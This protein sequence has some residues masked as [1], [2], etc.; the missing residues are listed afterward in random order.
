M[1]SRRAFALSSLAIGLGGEAWAQ[2]RPAGARRTIRYAQTPGAPATLQS[3]DLYPA[4]NRNAPL[5]VFIHGGGWRIGDKQNGAAGEEKASFFNALG[6]A[7]AS[8]NYRLSPEVQ[9]PAH[10]E[11]VAAALAWLHDNAAAQGFDRD[12]ITIMGHSAGAHLAALVAIDPR[13]LGKH[14]KPLSIVKGVILLDGAGY[15]VTRQAPAVIARGGF[16]GEMYS[17][18]FGADPA[19]WRDASPTLLV[20]RGRAIAPFLIVHA[21]RP[22]STSQSRTLAA[23]LRDVGVDAQL[24][25]AHGYTHAQVNRR[26]GETGEAVTREITGALAR[27]QG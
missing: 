1:M 13:Y 19:G 22:D 8:L 6:N 27:W 10:V 12:R 4:A 24:F 18:A 21:S 20:E 16:M 15:D 7:Y 3:L 25:E 11:D 5:V 17:G 14:G 23:R 26:I 2:G 9:H